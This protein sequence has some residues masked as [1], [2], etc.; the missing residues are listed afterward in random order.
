M[1]H[2]PLGHQ[3]ILASAGSGKTH[4]LTTRYLTLMAAGVAPERIIAL[5]FSRKAAGEFFS[6]ILSRLARAAGDA[7]EAAALDRAMREQERWHLS[8]QGKVGESLRPVL[9]QESATG[10]LVELVGRLHLLTLG[11]MDRFFIRMARSF[12]LE[13]GLGGDFRIL[14][15]QMETRTRRRIYDQLFQPTPGMRAAQEE[16]VAAF[17]HATQGKEG[18]SLVKDL[19]RFI[20]D[21][22]QYFVEAR[23]E[24]LWG[25]REVIWKDGGSPRDPGCT[26]AEAAARTLEFLDSGKH[27]LTL[28][29]VEAL[30]VYPQEMLVHTP[31]NVLKKSKPILTKLCEVYPA[32][33]DGSAM[34]MLAR[35]K[36]ALGVPL[37]ALLLDVVDAHNFGEFEAGRIQ[38]QG[39]WSVLNQ[40][41]Q[42][43]DSMVR[44]QGQLS[45][46]DVQQLLSGDLA[47]SEDAGTFAISRE[48]LEFRLDAQFDHWMLDEFQDTNGRQWGILENLINEVLQDD[49]GERTFFAVGDSKQSIHMWRGSDPDLMMRLLQ[50]YES[51][52]STVS[53]AVSWRCAPAVLSLVNALLG[54]RSALE[55]LLPA[56]T[57]AKAWDFEEHKPAPV[58]ENLLGFSEVMVVPKREGA[59][60]EDDDLQV[61]AE[62]IL[63]IQPL[64]RGLTCAVLVLTNT[65]AL[66]VAEYLR[67]A[68]GCSVACETDASVTDSD[69]ACMGLLDLLRL[70]A[71]P[72]NSFAR[73][74]L[75]MSPWK[76]V[77]V[78]LLGVEADAIA[79]AAIWIGEELSRGGVA[80]VV[81]TWVESLSEVVPELPDYSRERL[82]DLTSLAL[83]FDAEGTRDLDEYITLAEEKTMRESVSADS[84]QVL[85]AF[86]AKG[87]E[88]D[89]VFVAGLDSQKMAGGFESSAV[90]YT[91]ERKIE[92]ITRIPIKDLALLNPA[93]RTLDAHRRAWRWRQ[94]L[95]LLYVILTRAKRSSHVVLKARPER[96]DSLRLDTLI[97]DLLGDASVEPVEMASFEVERVWCHGEQDWFM[98]HPLSA[99]V[100]D[101]AGETN[102]T[103]SA[104][105]DMAPRIPKSRPSA[106]IVEMDF[107]LERQRSLRW[108]DAVHAVLARILRMKNPDEAWWRGLTSALPTDIQHDVVRQLR[109]SL[110]Q[111]AIAQ[112]FEPPKSPRVELW[113]ERPFDLVL[114]G[115][116]VSG[117][118][119]RVEV[120]RGKNGAA[121]EAR[122]YDFKTDKVCESIVYRNQ[123]KQYAR[124]VSLL[125]DLPDEK[126][127]ASLV[128]VATGKVEGIV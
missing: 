61:I 51:H 65:Q 46:S 15:P 8:W 91:A 24:E 13:L 63:E 93:M 128:W 32:M 86:K 78:R 47:E 41:D 123:L 69:A 88:W 58:S 85:T 116:H 36:V 102:P 3:M 22:N 98:Q 56:G 62:R 70:A 4:D 16:F 89:I 53:K 97:L 118:F 9:T 42:Q 40:Y 1:S 95:C 23:G 39:I 92:W 82:N 68:T 104:S 124:A 50:R 55:S 33:Q 30:K 59:A 105:V 52:I 115:Q 34:V 18:V 113:L 121:M 81:R 84:I 7:Q 25:R 45:F 28:P 11:T 96:S 49:G 76:S 110:E 77:A 27:L 108:G 73:R 107:S 111:P 17:Q 114:G 117:V 74:H 60:G 54:N 101:E 127:S 37:C 48:L 103:P 122:I 29:Q 64:R 112:L 80:A 31:F 44:R 119:D 66:E 90:S 126:I 109:W 83:D 94:N 67:E 100:A 21:Y 26:L 5:T 14:D 75:E 125:L 72:G 43:Y 71:H 87:L 38:V 2:F 19:D 57:V 35:K 79:K 6:R 12:A 106:S 120:H 10:L 99:E 20:D